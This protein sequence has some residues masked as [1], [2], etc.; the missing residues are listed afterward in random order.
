MALRT[1]DDRVEGIVAGQG[2]WCAVQ[3]LVAGSR[4]ARL[5]YAAAAP[6]E[7]RGAVLARVTSSSA[8]WPPALAHWH[9]GTLALGLSV[10]LALSLSFGTAA[11][12]APP[13][14]AAARRAS[15]V[16]GR[17]AA[18]RRFGAEALAPSLRLQSA[19]RGRSERWGQTGG[20]LE[21]ANARGVRRSLD[22]GHSA[23]DQTPSRPLPSPR[24]SCGTPTRWPSRF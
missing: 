22:M 13:A 6:P 3:Q 11:A 14:A 16:A 15:V 17:A 18:A 21:R 10:P 19:A 5:G 12:A 4:S 8:S 23:I 1:Y 7:G 2:G 9:T 24:P 20:A